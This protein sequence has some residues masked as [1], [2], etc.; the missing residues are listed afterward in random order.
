MDITLIIL[1]PKTH[2]Y[3][4]I[5]IA[6]GLERTRE[7]LLQRLQNKSNEGLEVEGEKNSLRR[8]TALLQQSLAE[9]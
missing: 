6:E 9:K 5:Y 7:E 1:P 3:I 4:Y 8:E 2:I